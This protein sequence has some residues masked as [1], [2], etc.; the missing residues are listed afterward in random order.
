MLRSLLPISLWLLAVTTTT[1]A[2]GI[3]TSLRSV[4]LKPGSQL[5]LEI[6]GATAG[7]DYDR[8]VASGG[9]IF[10]T[11]AANTPPGPAHA[12]QL[13]NGY[14]PP[15]GTGFDVLDGVVT[16]TFNTVTLPG[17]GWSSASLYPDGIVTFAI[18]NKYA[19]WL[20]ANIL[21]GPDAAGDADPDKDSVP[22]YAEY[23]LGSNPR[24]GA[25]GL[26]F[27]ADPSVQTSGN[28]PVPTLSFSLPAAPVPD[29]R[30][31]VQAQNG[32]DG[33]WSIIATR[34]GTGAWTGA[35][36]VETGPPAA[37]RMAV[38]VR[39]TTPV[40]TQAKRFF[41]LRFSPLN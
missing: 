36:T 24:S 3:L 22:N 37:G 23:S 38:I 14:Q 2:P 30:L 27:L 5:R 32:L 11:V 18:G 33:T 7:T 29:M 17:T 8:L 28:G 16:G 20:T 39:E 31:E 6:G 15:S 21:S 12:V 10:E 34:S 35:A 4:T 13:I 19:T 9:I 41:R 40:T 25:T 1:G 26:T